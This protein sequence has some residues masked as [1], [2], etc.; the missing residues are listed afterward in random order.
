MQGRPL[1]GEILQGEILDGDVRM[2][3]GACSGLCSVGDGDDDLVQGDVLERGRGVLGGGVLRRHGDGGKGRERTGEQQQQAR[4]QRRRPLERHS[5]QGSLLRARERE[6][7]RR[8]EERIQRET[9]A[10]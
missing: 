9:R 3:R 2:A 8:G 4:Q 6:R 10:R 5:P 1:Q 7:E